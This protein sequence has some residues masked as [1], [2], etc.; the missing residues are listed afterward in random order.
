MTRDEIKAPVKAA[1]DEWWMT[2][3]TTQATLEGCRTALRECAKQFRAMGMHGGHERM[4]DDHADAADAELLR[5]A[6]PAIR[7]DL[8]EARKSCEDFIERELAI[9]EEVACEERRLADDY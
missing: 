4:A 6:A 7:A 8:A 2:R 3:T 9:L 1:M 5:L